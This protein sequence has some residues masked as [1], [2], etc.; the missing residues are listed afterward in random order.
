MNRILIADDRA[1]SRELLGTILEGAGY[2]VVEAEN[3]ME[4]LVVARDVHPDLIILDLQMPVLDGF[5][6]IAQLRQDE[7][8]RKTPVIALTANAMPGDRER[9]LDAGFDT[10]LSKPVG[11][12]ALREEVSRLLNQRNV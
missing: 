12:V 4:A 7:G 10:Y 9:A 1:N 5:G 11:L 3:G 8:L 6:A 2:E